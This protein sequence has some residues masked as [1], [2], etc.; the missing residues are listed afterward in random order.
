MI[1]MGYDEMRWYFDIVTKKCATKLSEVSSLSSITYQMVVYMI[2]WSFNIFIYILFVC[3]F[4]ISN[5]IV[6][7][8]DITAEIIFAKILIFNL[9]N[10]N[11]SKR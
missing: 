7:R 1:L 5:H 8:F 2:N 11:D 4:T 10:K 9:I 3:L 6:Y